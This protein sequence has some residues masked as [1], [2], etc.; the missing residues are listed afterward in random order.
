MTTDRIEDLKDLAISLKN[1]YRIEQYF[2]KNLIKY[3][4]REFKV[5]D[6]SFY[7]SEIEK[8][9]Q[10]FINLKHV[11]KISSC[12]QMQRKSSLKTIK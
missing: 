6:D 10:D 11:A 9:L 7:S 3:K 2:Q 12:S 8:L 1:K 4:T 5:G